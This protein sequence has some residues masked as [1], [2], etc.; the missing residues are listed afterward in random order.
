MNDVLRMALDLIA[1]PQCKS[2][3]CGSHSCRFSG[4][5]HEE[6]LWNQGAQLVKR[7]QETPAWLRA[8]KTGARE[9]Q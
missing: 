3:Y 2:P 4:I 6:F 7:D 9:P 1:C 5:P 8:L